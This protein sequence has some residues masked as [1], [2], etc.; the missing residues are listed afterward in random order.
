MKIKEVE[1][2]FAQKLG[3]PLKNILHDL[4]Y[5]LPEH[6]QVRV[7][8]LDSNGRK[9]KS[10]AAA[11]NWSPESGRIEIRF[12]PTPQEEEQLSPEITPANLGTAQP[13]PHG[14]PANAAGTTSYIH[15]AEAELLRALERAESRPGWNFVPLKKFRDEILPQE[16]R[17]LCPSLRTDVEQRHMLES[18]IEKRLILTG[19]VPNPRSP[20]FPVTIIRLNRLMPEVKAALGQRDNPDLDFR[21]ID[22]G[23]EP[24]STTIL[25][26]RR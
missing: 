12:E 6:Y 26:E 13:Q 23:G 8:M 7:S 3:N 19:K 14:V 11:N 25:R 4:S 17:E 18:A 15:P 10:N 2:E 9:K 20:Q 1:P 21:P 22:I 5:H 24:L 16:P